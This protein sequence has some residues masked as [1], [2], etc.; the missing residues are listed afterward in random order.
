MSCHDHRSNWCSEMSTV[1]PL[2][3]KL[4]KSHLLATPTDGRLAKRMKEVM[5][6]DLQTRYSNN[7]LQMLSKAAFLD[8][9]LKELTFMSTNEKESVIEAIEEEAT[10]LAD[11]L[12]GMSPT[13]ESADQPPQ[14][15]KSNGEHTLFELIEDIIQPSAD[16]ELTITGYQKASAELSLFRSEPAASCD[17]LV[18][19]KANSFRFPILST[20]ARKYLAIP[21]T[22]VPSERAFS[23]AGHIVNKK[24]ACLHPETVNML[25]FLSNNIS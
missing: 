20:L 8:P 7:L 16:M 24:R 3:H 12:S 4:L 1:R 5:A 17:P 14:P 23:A 10:D 6:G 2:L 19:W 21:A 13:S 25:V 9:R 15:K 22:S 11:N 18:W